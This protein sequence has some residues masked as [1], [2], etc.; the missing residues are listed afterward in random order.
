MCRPQILDPTEFTAPVFDLVDG[1]H[2]VIIVT[3]MYRVLKYV[4]RYRRLP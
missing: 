4:V 3:I 2:P 1:R